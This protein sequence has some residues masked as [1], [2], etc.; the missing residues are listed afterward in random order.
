MRK[1][2]VNVGWEWV[3]PQRP[4]PVDGWSSKR[5]EDGFAVMSST[6]MMSVAHSGSERCLSTSLSA[7][8]WDSTRL[9]AVIRPDRICLSK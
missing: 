2:P 8:T 5:N 7:P 4:T 6:S 3:F 9:M 1:R